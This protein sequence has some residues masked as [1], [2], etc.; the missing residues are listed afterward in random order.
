ML[1]VMCVLRSGGGTYNA[2]WVGKLQRAVAR[3]L[4]IPHRFV[5]LSDVEVP[6]E[7]I[8]LLH[9][10][11]G[12]WSKIELFRPGVITGPTIYFDLDTV[13]VG[14]FDHIADNPS[15]FAMLK[16]FSALTDMVGSGVM[17]FRDA[18]SVPHKVY[19]K[20]AKMPE[21][22]MEHHLRHADAASSYIGDQAFIWDTL[23]CRVDTLQYPG[24]LS[25]K[26]H[27]RKLLPADSSIVAFH[28][29]PRPSEVSDSWVKEHWN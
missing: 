22:Y 2:S 8:P 11:P 5:C 24:I 28:G 7:R 15:P 1:T 9:D 26:R 21:C 6:C 19:Q 20:F 4:T 14:N 13:I 23:A 25:Y 29:Q 27:C 10:W 18:E 3:N 17:W 16:N 12:W